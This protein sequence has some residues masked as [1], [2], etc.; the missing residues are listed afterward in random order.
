MSEK[1]QQDA[2]IINPQFIENMRQALAAGRPVRRKLPGGGRLHIDRQ[3]PFLCIYR[4]PPERPDPG[5]KRLLLG[6]AA[7]IL[8]SGESQAHAGL[9]SLVETILSTQIS[10]F[11]AALLLE[12]W[13]A[14][15]EQSPVEATAQRPSIRVVV[16]EQL[17]PSNLLER[18]ETFLLRI[19]VS[20]QTPRITL[21]YREDFTPPDQAPLIEEKSTRLPGLFTLG[22]EIDPVYRDPASEEVFPYKLK[23]LHHGLAHALKRAFYDFA[24]QYTRHRPAHYHELG[25]HAMTTPVW[26]A[27]SQL[28]GISDCFDLLLHVTPIN[29]AQAWG[30]FREAEFQQTPEFH[31]RPR[32]MDPDLLKRELYGIPI[33][34]IEDP[35][36]AYIFATKRDELARQISL[37]GDRNTPCFIHGSQQIYGVVE[38]WLLRLA[39]QIVEMVPATGGA[40]SSEYLDAN[41]FAQ[42]AREEMDYYKNRSSEFTA[43][44]EV[45]EDITGILV[46]KGNFLI[47]SDAKVARERLDATLSHEIG[48]HVLTHYNGSQQPFHQLHAGMAGYE[49]LQ[50]GMAV[51]SEYLVGQLSA[52]RLRMLAGRVLAVHSL[53]QGTAFQGT[54]RLLRD[55]YG[56]NERTAFNISMRVYRGGGY[57]KDAVY[58]RGLT[59]LL[60]YLGNGGDYELLFVG[61]VALE[62]LPFIEELKWRRIIKPA[63]LRPRYLDKPEAMQRLQRIQQGMTL[64]QLVEECVQ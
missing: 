39:R 57:T 54:F 18:L 17:A 9:R 12:L 44:V 19:Q 33:E 62:F 55:E 48:T 20:G 50:E 34:R 32:P 43:K 24:H 37:V 46:S 30:K 21:D 42:N 10:Q 63:T 38:D 7:Y 28:A 49:P 23:E 22:L 36:L 31:Y 40:G 64:A 4:R 5:T 13:S 27:D 56:F 6:E 3:L 61:K 25:R 59:Q 16:S 51:L 60:E 14:P 8:A 29:A 15:Q 26:E 52:S 53:S 58:L 47:S 11:G 45:R 2:D 1:R 41:A 35:T